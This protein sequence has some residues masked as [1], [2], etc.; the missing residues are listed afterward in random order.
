MRL[1]EICCDCCPYTPTCEE[2][3][4]FLRDIGLAD[5]WGES[6]AEGIGVGWQVTRERRGRPPG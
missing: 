4:E 1:R 2:E 6:S 3:N 5:E